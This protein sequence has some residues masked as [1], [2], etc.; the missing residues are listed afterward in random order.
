MLP[1]IYQNLISTT[2]ASVRS[3]KAKIKDKLPSLSMPG[4]GENQSEE[5]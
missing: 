3:I 2:P 5:Y 1:K 4:E